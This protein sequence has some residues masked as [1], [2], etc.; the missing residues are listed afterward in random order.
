MERRH[1]EDR[2][3]AREKQRQ[4]RASGRRTQQ[5]VT[6]GASRAPKARVIEGVPA[7]ARL[8]RQIAHC[9]LTSRRFKA[10]VNM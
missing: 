2:D 9:A 7:G 1:G 3:G 10:S 6:K 5:P 4:Q 8:G